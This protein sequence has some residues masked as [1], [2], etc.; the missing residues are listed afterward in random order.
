MKFFGNANLQQNQLQQAV[1]PL[2]LAFPGVPKVGQIAFVNKILYICVSVTDGLPVWVPLSQELTLYTHNQSTP[3]TT[4]SIV[5][6]LNTTSVQ[7]QVFDANDRV[8]IPDEI[9]VTSANTATVTVNTAF[10]GRAVVLTGHND[11]IAKPT[12]SYLHYQT[13]SASTW[14]ITH[15]LGREPIVRVFVGNQEVQPSSITHTSVNQLS[16][17]FGAPYAGIVKLI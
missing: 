8:V 11:G 1:I 6:N 9:T 13:E 16:V 7:V 4:W 10:A 14:T 17:N 12:Y 2:E 15:N 5:H 3:A